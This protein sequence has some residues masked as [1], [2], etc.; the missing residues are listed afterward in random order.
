MIP[1]AFLF[2]K[3]R[4]VLARFALACALA[5]APAAQAQIFSDE[6]TKAQLEEQK[7]QI[8][9]L[10][11]H[12]IELRKQNKAMQQQ[13]SRV[14][15][16]LQQAET[17]LREL[18]GAQQEQLEAGRRQQAGANAEL[19]RQLAE[20]EK[21][22]ADLRVEVE[23][24][25]REVSSVNKS[26]AD[27]SEFISLPPE[28]DIYDAAFAEFQGKRYQSALDGFRRV[29][30]FY[31]H[32]KFNANAGYWISN[33]L[34]AL[35]DFEGVVIN[36]QDLLARHAGSDKAPDAMLLLARAYA[37][38]GRTDEA[39]EVLRRIIAEHSTSLAADKARQE[40]TP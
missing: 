18:R 34:L 12:V 29:Q 2:G 39:Q 8:G 25:R 26:V 38:L 1:S 17:E 6:E 11:T 20:A 9:Q 5:L 37:Q 4:A 35:E 22:I 33:A 24:T 36:T 28:Q 15:Q 21:Q 40:L 30:K 3:A 19:K 23:T 13:L 14:V 10:S 32:G 31:P 16:Q 27:M 7:K